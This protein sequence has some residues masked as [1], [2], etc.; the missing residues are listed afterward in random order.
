VTTSSTRDAAPPEAG[1]ARPASKSIARREIRGSS[2]LLAGRLLAL[3][4]KLV[5]Q[6]ILVRYLTVADYGAWAY[7]LS[8]VTLLGGFAHLSLDRAVTRFTAIY[9]EQRAYA[10]FFGAIALVM[11]T[12]VA[13]GVLFVGGMHLFHHQIAHLLGQQE[14]SFA[15]LLILIVVVPLEA[16]D[17]LLVAILAS[18]SST[19]AIFVRRYVMAPAIQLGAVLL[20]ALMHARVSFLA[21]AYVAGA[22]VGAATS[23]W[24][25]VGILRQQGLLG[26][27]RRHGVRIPAR[28][29][30]TFSVPL[31]TSDWLATMLESS[32]TVVL[33][34]FYDPEHVAFFRT[35]FPLAVLNKIVMQSF[36]TLYEP[37]V[38][39][40]FARGDRRGI[41]DFYW[42]TTI[43]I[44]VLTFPI[45]A[46]TFA[47][48]TPLTVLLYGARYE[49]A[50]TLLAIL[51]VG[52]YLQAVSGFNG[53]TIKAVGRVNYLVVINLLALGVNVAVTLLL[54]PPF[55]PVGAAVA[56]TTTLVIHNVL[57]QV[58]LHRATAIGVP[59]RRLVRPFAMVAGTIGALATLLVLRVASPVLLVAAAA[60][61][62]VMVLRHARHHLRIAEVFPELARIRYLRILFT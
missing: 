32:G 38:A 1:P 4:S 31:M 3:G 53:M 57:K 59:E 10:H 9:H 28:E 58:G 62:V 7:A 18:L 37:A 12:V 11:C 47:V 26:E 16:L 54:V 46:L 34:Y 60:G 6:V 30:I 35:V 29:M 24:L 61:A 40:L 36:G 27:L 50:G 51:A 52:Q 48:S 22:L 41:A 5:A 14:H 8:I 44:A 25:L 19:R 45:F 49:A 15:L 2:L 39:R 20:L 42:E 55:G 23:A 21:W 13:T 17:T 56:L 33:G 43:W